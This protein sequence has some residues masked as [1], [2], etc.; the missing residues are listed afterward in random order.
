MKNDMKLVKTLF[1]VL[2]V[3]LFS[4]ASFGQKQTL[5]VAKDFDSVMKQANLEKKPVVLM[6]YATWCVHCNVM[7]NDVFNKENVINF[8]NQNYICIASDIESSEGKLLREKL[9]SQ[10]IVKSYPTFVYFDFNGTITNAI[11]G[12]FKPEKFIEEGTNNLKEDFHFKNVKSSFENNSADYDKSYAYILMAKRIGFNPTE[13]AQRYLKTVAPNDYYTEKNWRLIANGILD[14]DSPVFLD[15][16]KNRAEFEKVVSKTRVDKKIN[17]VINENF[18]TYILESNTIKY[19][20]NRSIAADFKLSEI[21]SLL[22]FKDLNFYEH[23]NKWNE[24]H[25]V[26]TQNIDKFGLN[27]AQFINSVAA[28]YYMFIDDKKMLESAIDWQQK[29][30]ELNPSLD[31][32]VLLSNLALKSK[33]Y[34]LGIDYASQGIEF[35]K[36]LGFKT[37]EIEQILEQLKAKNKK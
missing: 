10:L 11:A 13:I 6:F 25:A 29:A 23:N 26:L 33:N 35:G 1:S 27:D 36:N 30:I 7:K 17:F 15:L 3:V 16:I 28:N 22:F 2:L 9:K 24:Y 31:K 20:K 4:N 34:K 19:I 8:Y 37:T 14:F 12:E 32:Y 5:F 18:S 21:D